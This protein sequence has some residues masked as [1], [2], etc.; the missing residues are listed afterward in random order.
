MAETN[1][2]TQAPPIVQ[3][4]VPTTADPRQAATEKWIAAQ[5]AKRTAPVKEPKAEPAP[6]AEAPEEKAEPAP[7]ASVKDLAA[8]LAGKEPAPKKAG[9][10]DETATKALSRIGLREQEAAELSELLAE[11]PWVSGWLDKLQKVQAK[12]DADYAALKSAKADTGTREPTPGTQRPLVQER[13]D[14]PGSGQVADLFETLTSKLGEELGDENAKLLRQAFGALQAQNQELREELHGHTRSVQVERE[15][16]EIEVIVQRS[17]ASLREEFPWIDDDA[18]FE[19]VAAELAG[20]RPDEVSPDGIKAAMRKAARIVG[21][22]EVRADAAA[23]ASKLDTKRKTRSA[24]TAPGGSNAGDDGEPVLDDFEISLRT[25]KMLE[26]Q[27][28]KERVQRW[29]QQQHER[30]RKANR[31]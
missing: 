24:E 7:K 22:D 16:A 5:E 31:R 2:T 28:P 13:G 17:R 30:R 19:A 11:K 3:N 4:G 6:K 9:Q 26:A 15:A 25:M 27:E 21:Y 10:W 23:L 20:L 29:V 18:R 14:Q 12:Q 1:E 8:K